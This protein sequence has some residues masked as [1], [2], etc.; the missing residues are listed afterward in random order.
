MDDKV[1]CSSILCAVRYRKRNVFRQRAQSAI[2][3]RQSVVELQLYGRKWCGCSIEIVSRNIRGWT[4]DYRSSWSNLRCCLRRTSGGVGLHR[5]DSASEDNGNKSRF[6][7]LYLT[8]R[9]FSEPS[10]I[11]CEV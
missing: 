6:V 1:N 4:S 9:N 10:G 2:R 8:R 3:Y 5:K 11:L 7:L